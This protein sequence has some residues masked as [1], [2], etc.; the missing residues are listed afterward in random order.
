MAR[1]GPAA[2]KRSA[3]VIQRDNG[4]VRYRFPMPDKKHARLA[5]AMLPR[6]KGLSRKERQTIRERAQEM[7]GHTGTLGEMLK[8]NA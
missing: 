2:R 4:D 3:T 5:L 6:A 8:R 1:L 7:L